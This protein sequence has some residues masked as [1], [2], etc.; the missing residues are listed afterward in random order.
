MNTRTKLTL[1]LT[2]VSVVLGLMVSLGYR[3]TELSARLGSLTS[4]SL[5]VNKQLTSKLANLKA[6]NQDLEQQLAAVTAEVNKY[7]QQSAGS[8]GALKQLQTKIQD[9]RILAGTTPVHG[10]GVA[11]TLNDA[12][13]T[14]IDVEQGITHDWNV[15][16]VVNE[17]F[18]AGAE[19]VTINGVRV[20]A[21]SA[22]NCQGPTVTVNDRQLT[23]PFEVDAIGDPTTL[24]NALTLSGGI[25]DALR[26]QGLQVSTPALETDIQMPAYTTPLQAGVGK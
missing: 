7:E 26:Q 3:Q 9:E 24:K 1:S 23:A 16:S 5:A 13:T 12:G 19:A 25:L 11:V 4:G 10:P 8:S 17:L 20:V 18:T 14:G 21:T 15:R 22:V 2:A 6:A